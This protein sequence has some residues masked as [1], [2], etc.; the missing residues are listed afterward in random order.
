[1]NVRREYYN[2]DSSQFDGVCGEREDTKP[3]L[4]RLTCTRGTGY[5]NAEGNKGGREPWDM[6]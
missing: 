1:M 3:E 4:Y 5:G 6:A 2:T